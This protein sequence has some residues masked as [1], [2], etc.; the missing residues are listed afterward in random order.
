MIIYILGKINDLFGGSV[1][2][3]PDVSWDSDTV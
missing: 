2:H 3:K 1:L